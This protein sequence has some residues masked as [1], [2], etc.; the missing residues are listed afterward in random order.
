MLKLQ[1]RDRRQ[2]AI[3]LVDPL[4]TIGRSPEN[5]LVIKEAN[6]ADF[7]VEIRNE[8]NTA[9]IACRDGNAA[10]FI[11]DEKVSKPKKLA[12]GD[13]IRL[14]KTELDVID[15]QSTQYKSAIGLTPAK[16]AEWKLKSTASWMENQL[17]PIEGKT[18]LGRDA[19][20]NISIPV[21]HLSR[22]HAE[23]EVKGGKLFVK[24]LDSSNGTF[25]NGNRITESYAKPGDKIKLDVITFEVIG[26]AADPNKTII[27]SAAEFSPS[28]KNTANRQT[29]KSAPKPAANTPPKAQAAVKKPKLASQ[30]K[31]P[32]IE[33]PTISQKKTNYWWFAIA[34]FS[35]TLLAIVLFL[36]L[37]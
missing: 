32:W 4:F 13:V 33:R 3:W 11:N 31:Q 18:I 30:G 26:P 23:L 20:C 1:F 17:F 10:L 22:R 29:T 37:R 25:L 27:R 8:N 21:E 35:V 9:T 7:H 6:I 16:T 34:G 19:S 2:E 24:D 12:P 15:P 5:S 28:K 36:S 14:G